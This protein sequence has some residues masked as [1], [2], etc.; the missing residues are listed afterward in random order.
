MKFSR[1]QTRRKYKKIP[2]LQFE[3]DSPMTACAGLVLFQALFGRLDL[4][5]RLNRCFSHLD[6]DA[7]YRHGLVLLQLVVQ[8]LLGYRH[9]RARDLIAG[10]P[11]VLRLLGVTRLADVATISRVLSGA[12]AQSVVAMR[13]VSRDLVLERVSS[14]KPRVVTLDFDG[15]VQSTTGHAEGTAVGFNKKKKGARSYYPLLCTVAQTGQVLDLHHRP[16][17]VHDSNGA[18]DFMKSCFR[19]VGE[20][21]PKARL[22]ARFDAAFFDRALVTELDALGVQFSG[23]VPFQRFPALK[24]QIHAVDEWQRINNIW[25][26]ASTD[27][28]PKSWPA[29]FRFILFRRRSAVQRKGP[30]Q[31][32]LFEPRDFNWE[33]KAVVTSKQAEHP[34]TVLAFHNGRGSQEKIIGELK[35]HT[36]FD[37]IPTRT[38]CGNQLFSLSGVLAHNLG[39]EL[40]M[41]CVQRTRGTLPK[42]PARWRFESLGTLRR[43]LILRVGRLVRPQNRLTLRIAGDN[44][45]QREMRGYMNALQKAA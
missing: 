22:E 42:R 36:A 33:Y 41:Q 31:L 13:G 14:E 24:A 37:A 39:R 3:V 17:N 6:G 7:V 34:R 26:Y 8:I 44:S 20:H 35:Q 29:C 19:A 25:E 38:L 12:D 21:L 1:P 2:S 11:M 43:R 15:T 9:L 40:Q 45:I 18:L 28:K 27:W 16:G 5:T 23:S 10:D 4:K 30:L 32:D